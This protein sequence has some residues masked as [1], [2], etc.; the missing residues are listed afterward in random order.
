VP[1][2][3]GARESLRRRLRDLR[4]GPRAARPEL[5]AK[6]ARRPQLPG[7]RLGDDAIRIGVSVIAAVFAPLMGALLTGYFAYDAERDGRIATRNLMIMLLGFSLV[8]VFAYAQLWGGLV[9]G[10]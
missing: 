1:Q 6:R 9:L 4:H 2:L 8:G 10:L 7:V 3:Q 5:A